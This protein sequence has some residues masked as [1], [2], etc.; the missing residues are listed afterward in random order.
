MKLQ[1]ADD[2]AARSLPHGRVLL[3]GLALTFERLRT[4]S[5]IAVSL[6]LLRAIISVAV[7]EMPFEP[8]F[9]QSTYPDIREAYEAGR[10]TDLRTHFIETGYFEGRFGAEPAFDEQ[11]YKTTYP[12]VVE[13]LTAGKANSAFDHYL[14]AGAF[15][16]RHA[17]AVD[18]ESAKQWMKLLQP[19]ETQQIG[20][21]SR[22]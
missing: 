19:S 12:D 13:A 11:F 17:N 20:S 7:S 4:P 8:L 16:G 21:G 5:K 2:V 1:D 14:R 18:Q 10:I 3:D 9:Y 22:R 6:P 15:E